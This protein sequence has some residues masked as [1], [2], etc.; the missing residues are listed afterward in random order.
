MKRYC[1]KCGSEF[2]PRSEKGKYCSDKCR[3]AAYRER[4][5]RYKNPKDTA[6]SRMATK[7]LQ[8]H[9]LRCSEC[10]E[11]F[12]VNGG[13]LMKLYCSDRCKKSAAAA[14]KEIERQ[15]Y[16]MKFEASRQQKLSE[17]ARI[18]QGVMKLIGAL[19]SAVN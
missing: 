8:T 2:H 7:R 16:L 14:R 11:L 4:H 10:N 1:F 3:V 5:R 18:R 6:F 19:E 12:P 13:Q 17:Q 15:Q 9:W